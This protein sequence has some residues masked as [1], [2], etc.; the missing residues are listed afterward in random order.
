MDQLR[1]FFASPMS[2]THWVQAELHE[3]ERIPEGPCLLVGNHGPL[4]VD[5]P[6]LVHALFERHGIL[7]RPLA[8]RLFYRSAFGRRMARVTASVEAT[9]DNALAILAAGEPVLVY[10][11]GARETQR[12]R[13][14]RYTLSWEGRQGFVRVAMQADVPVS[15][16]NSAS[17]KGRD[18][19][20]A[21]S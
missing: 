15:T 3:P 7:L 10:P 9:P 19:A 17:P 11:G 16:S 8:D 14:A 6:I 5:T 20:G 13:K 18:C 1:S 12:D 4:G 21:C 2:P